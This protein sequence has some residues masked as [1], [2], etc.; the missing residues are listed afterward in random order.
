MVGIG[1]SLMFGF[2]SGPL[3][4]VDAFAAVRGFTWVNRGVP[5][6]TSGQIAARFAADVV[7]V[8]PRYVLLEGGI[9]DI[10]TSVFPP[11]LFLAHMGTMLAQAF[12]AGIRALVVAMPPAS[13]LSNVQSVA[14]DQANADLRAQ[15][16]A[17][18]Y[19]ANTL[20]VDYTPVVGQF[21]AGGPGGNLWDLIPADT[22]DGLHYTQAVY[23]AVG[24]S[25]AN[26]FF[27]AGLT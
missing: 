27:A 2:P 10:I 20:V 13:T 5:G 7:A 22:A 6:E 18:S 4:M 16:A 14:R 24:R 3:G 1:D 26:Q 15:I 9:N 19:A 25:I 11:S 12:A 23:P 21:R 8:K 17:A